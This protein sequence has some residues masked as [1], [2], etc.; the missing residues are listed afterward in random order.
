MPSREPPW[1]HSTPAGHPVGH[2]KPLG[3]RDQHR[4]RS[5][6]RQHVRRL[7]SIRLS[8]RILTL[9]AIAAAL[10][11]ASELL[12]PLVLAAFIAL[13][14]NPIVAALRRLHVPRALGSVLLIVALGAVVVGGISGLSGPAASWLR[15]TPVL[16]H[17]INARVKRVMA[18]IERM[19][20]VASMS[21]GRSNTPSHPAATASL[22]TGLS[23]AG[24]LHTAP[25][26]LIGILTVVLLVF[27]FLAY[28]RDVGAHLVTAMPG[29]G[30]RRTAVRVIQNI[31]DEFSRWLLTKTIINICLGLATAVVLWLFRMPDPL[32]WGA[33][34]ALLN[35][36][37]YVGA[38][39]NTL[40]LLAVGLLNFNNAWHAV[41]PAACFVVL[42]V[43]EGSVVTPM[44]MGNRLRI[45][46]LAI[47]VW[48][49]IWGFLWG[50]PGAL[51]AV[52]ILTCLKVITAWLPGWQWFS[53][54][55]EG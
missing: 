36:M 32:L 23:F 55:I 25:R 33:S 34:V 4:T 52:P 35:Y 17:K 46:P 31:Q 49:L 10:I 24:I 20:H 42:A 37:P 9:L 14:L 5:R 6:T 41:L 8:L 27:F 7:R 22:G 30:Y 21:L 45:S 16:V 53:K 3:P 39:A 2:L 51:L 12:I 19:T 44:V 43:L 13:G 28:G 40:L 18:P 54:M 47:L 11:L 48:L 29:F 50:I 1:K 26:I 15:Q 38:A